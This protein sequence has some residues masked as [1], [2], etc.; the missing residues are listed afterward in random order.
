MP[1]PDTALVY[2]GQCLFEGDQPVGG[3]RHDAAVR[4]RR[5][6]VPRRP[7]L[8]GGARES[9]PAGRAVSAADVPADVSQV[10][11]Q[12]VRRRAAP[13]HRSRGVPTLPDGR[14][15]DRG[16]ARAGR[17]PVPLADANRTSSSSD[18]PAIDLLT[19]SAEVR[20]AIERGAALRRY[21]GDVRCRSSASSPSCRRPALMLEYR[22]ST[23]APTDARSRS[24]AA[25]STRRTSRTSW[26]RCTCWRPR[27][28]DELWFVA[29]VRARVRQAAGAV[30]RT[31]WRCA[32]WRRRRWGRARRVSDIERALGGA[33]R[34]LRT[35][36]RLRELHPEH[37]FSLV[38]GA[39]LLAEVATWFGGDE[40]RAHGAVHRRRPAGRGAASRTA[41]PAR[42]TCRRS[43]RPTCAPR[44]R[45]GRPSRRSCRGPFSTTYVEQGLYRGR[46]PERA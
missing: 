11:G 31:A 20:R 18:P 3:A 35:V 17:R 38:I 33:S 41:A 9:A 12:A 25:A 23:S 6:A 5:R 4:D 27:P 14:R 8:G 24:S 29:R 32:S 42:S 44:S 45:P 7:R 28:V 34:T 26:W 37:A 2:P 19:G 15:V 39:D 21:R 16:G 10:R 13:R 40:L 43:A 22:L 46:E 30:R 36:R 1:T